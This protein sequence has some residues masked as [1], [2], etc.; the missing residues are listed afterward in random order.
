MNVLRKYKKKPHCSI[1]PFGIEITL[2]YLININYSNL[3]VKLI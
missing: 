3:K 1:A 2:K